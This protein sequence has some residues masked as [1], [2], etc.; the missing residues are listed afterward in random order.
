[1]TVSNTILP[2]QVIK[3]ILSNDEY[4]LFTESIK[5]PLPVTMR[6]NTLRMTIEDFENHL[7]MLN[8]LW[9][10]NP[11][12]TYAYHLTN[13]TDETNKW[14]TRQ[15]LLGVLYAQNFSSM[16]P[17]LALEIENNL[18][19]LTDLKILDICAAPGSKTT[20]LSQ[21]M[22]NYGLIIA[23]DYSLHK[24]R[25]AFILHRNLKL[26]GCLNTIVSTIDARRSDKTSLSSRWSNFFDYILADVPCT[27]TGTIRGKDIPKRSQDDLD[28]LVERQKAILQTA[29][30]CVQPHGMVIYSTCSYLPQE[31]ELIL[32]PLIENG[33]LSIEPLSISG[34]HAHPGLTYFD[35]IELPIQL[36][37][38]CR[39]YP[40]D[41]DSVGFFIA[42]LKIKE[43]IDEPEFLKNISDNH[44]SIEN[45]F[46]IP[47]D[48]EHWKVMENEESQLF[49][50]ELYNQFGISQDN[51]IEDFTLIK[52]NHGR[53]WLATTQAIRFLL[54]LHW[55]ALERLLVPI[56]QQ[57]QHSPRY[58]LTIDGVLVFH[59]DITK[60]IYILSKQQEEEWFTGKEI[61]IPDDKQMVVQDKEQKTYVILKSSSSNQLIGCSKQ[62]TNGGKTFLLNFMPRLRQ[63]PVDS[64]EKDLVELI[65]NENES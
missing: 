13:L 14:I 32:A 28:K 53:V 64:I 4:S 47:R 1:M 54:K 12:L 24:N 58:R 50:A 9:D 42:K 20:Q 18:K 39:I 10:K 25:R 29:I 38:A 43:K 60:N 19:T 7:N 17:P 30:Q 49:W 63:F 5:R 31:N 44:E 56:A 36:K 11:Y 22:R 23:N 40:F 3:S 55:N 45:E 65:T 46:S 41:H 52:N 16:I 15:R 6:L 59:K 33:T 34:L 26:M 8:V 57:E 48:K 61:I 37:N 51:W 62:V 2:T 35:K 21:I 27:G